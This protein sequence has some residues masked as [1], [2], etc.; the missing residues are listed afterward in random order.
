[1]TSVRVFYYTHHLHNESA[2]YEPSLV[3]LFSGRKYGRLGPHVF[4]YDA[5][6]GLTAHGQLPD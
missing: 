2:M 4:N 6:H 3:L 5:A 1:M